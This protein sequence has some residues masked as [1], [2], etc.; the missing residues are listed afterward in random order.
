MNEKEISRHSRHRMKVSTDEWF[1]G[2]LLV[3]SKAA[4]VVYP[5]D[6]IR[7]SEF[8]MPIHRIEAYRESSTAVQFL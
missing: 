6:A 2:P 4:I 5:V 7:C 3:S 8:C 1:C